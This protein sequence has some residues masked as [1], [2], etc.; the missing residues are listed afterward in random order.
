MQTK[1]SSDRVRCQF[2]TFFLGAVANKKVRLSRRCVRRICRL[3]SRKAEMIFC[4]FSFYLMA[5]KNR[6]LEVSIESAQLPTAS[7]NTN[8]R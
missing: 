4:I 3:R 6:S 5:A 7:T 2:W 8:G 1:R